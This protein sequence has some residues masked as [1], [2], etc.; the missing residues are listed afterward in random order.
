MP[1]LQKKPAA[2]WPSCESC[3]ICYRR[4]RLRYLSMA[5]WVCQDREHGCRLKTLGSPPSNVGYSSSARSVMLSSPLVVV[6]ES[7]FRW[8]GRI[9]LAFRS[10]PAFLQY[11]R[12]EGNAAGGHSWTNEDL[13]P[14][15]PH[16]Q[17]WR[18]YNFC[19]FWFGVGFGNW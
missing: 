6:R 15:P 9:R 16:M 2:R 18:W 13:K 10:K 14:S 8:A 5:S 7:V 1:Y 19:L 12:T 17:N 3:Y 11:I 4:S